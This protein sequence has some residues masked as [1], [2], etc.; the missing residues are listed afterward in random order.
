M[1]GTHFKF[2]LVQ[3]DKTLKISFALYPVS[4]SNNL[5]HILM[6]SLSQHLQPE[7]KANIEK[8]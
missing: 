4:F 1:L 3:F 2:L 5:T 8:Q 7:I 6:G